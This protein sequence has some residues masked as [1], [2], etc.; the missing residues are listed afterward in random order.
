MPYHGR[1]QITARKSCNI[2]RSV[3][4]IIHAKHRENS[5]V[6]ASDILTLTAMALSGDF[7]SA[8]NF[9]TDFSA[10]ASTSGLHF[11]LLFA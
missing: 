1:C 5:W 10:I 9:V 2:A 6:A 3:L 11:V 7:L 8:V 4:E